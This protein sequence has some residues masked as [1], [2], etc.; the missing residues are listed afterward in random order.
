MVLLFNIK[1]NNSHE[2]LLKSCKDLYFKL[3]D[4]TECD[5]NST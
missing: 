5:L 2:N 4:E 1:D 3:N